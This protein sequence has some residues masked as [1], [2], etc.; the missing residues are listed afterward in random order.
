MITLWNYRLENVGVPKGLKTLVSERLFT[1]NRLKDPKHC[2]ISTAAF[3]SYF[4][5][6]LKTNQVEKFFFSSIC[7]LE[8]F[9]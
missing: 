9:C 5:T 2:L 3:L 7:N 4:L 6:T 1:V 8:N